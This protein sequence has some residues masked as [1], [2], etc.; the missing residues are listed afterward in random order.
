M[1]RSRFTEHQILNILKYVENGR[2]V[3]DVCREHYSFYN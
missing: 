1:K 2:L 3:K